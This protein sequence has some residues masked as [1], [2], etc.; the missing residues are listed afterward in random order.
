ME[1]K[2]HG[3][4]G[5]V[6]CAA[7]GFIA[8]AITIVGWFGVT[9]D[10]VGAKAASLFRVAAPFLDAL[11]GFLTGWSLRGIRERKRGSAAKA[12]CEAEEKAKHDAIAR[13]FESLNL[14]QA[15][16]MNI[17]AAQ[18]NGMLTK[19]GSDRHR[20]FAERPDVAVITESSE[21]PDAVR[22]A[23][24]SE[25]NGLMNTN[26]HIFDEVW[27]E[28]IREFNVQKSGAARS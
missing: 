28:K 16:S 7:F 24:T 10:M 1:E 8:S 12:E 26:R 2:Q 25:W 6:I 13:E 20:A 21:N 9:P 4:I 15:M 11:F 3:P 19:R 22:I 18:P 27:A 14:M 23:L 17:I 5:P